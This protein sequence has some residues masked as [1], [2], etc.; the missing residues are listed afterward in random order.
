MTHFKKIIIRNNHNDSQHKVIISHHDHD[1]YIHNHLHINNNHKQ[2]QLRYSN[3][4]RNQSKEYSNNENYTRKIEYIS[5]SYEFFMNSFLSQG[6]M[7]LLE[8]HKEK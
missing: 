4:Q 6:Y 2:L 3:L 5:H 1:H 8:T 7:E